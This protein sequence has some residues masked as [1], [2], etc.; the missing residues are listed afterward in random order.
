MFVLP[1][2]GVLFALVLTVTDL[3][4]VDTPPHGRR[5]NTP[6]Q[7]KGGDA[8]STIRRFVV[9]ALIT[10]AL[11]ASAAVAHAQYTRTVVCTTYPSGVTVCRY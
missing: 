11:M 1:S 3:E 10:A 8:M 2:L 7:Q 9:A 6:R 5:S 4:L